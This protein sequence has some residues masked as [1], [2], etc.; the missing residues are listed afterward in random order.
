MKYLLSLLVIAFYTNYLSAQ[1]INDNIKERLDRFFTNYITDCSIGKCKLDYFRIDHNK[2]T[3]KIYPNVNFGYQ[4]FTKEKSAAIYDSIRKIL[5]GPVNYYSIQ[6]ISDKKPI[7]DLIPN[8]FSKKKDKS[9]ILNKK[10]E[11]KPWVTNKSKPFNIEKGLFNKH[12]VIWQ[13]HGKYYKNRSDKWEWQRPSLYCTNED[14]FSLSFVVPYVIPMLENAGANVFTPRER[15]W[16]RNEVIVDNDGGN[17]YYEK[18]SSKEKWKTTNMPGFANIKSQYSD[19]D[20]PFKNGTARYINT[21]KKSERAFAQWIPTI[22]QTGKYAVY[23]SYQTREESVDDAS[24]LVFHKGGVTRFSVNQKMGGGTWVYLGTFEFD[25]G[26]N[27]YGMVVLSNESKHKGVVCADAVRFGGGMGN[28]IRG[29][30]VSGLP[31]FLEG[32]RYSAQ[33]Y[34]MPDS[35]YTPSKG[36]NDYT[37]DINSRGR[38]ANYLS[39][40]S[41][42]NPNKTGLKVPID[43]CMG[44]HTDAGY[45]EKDSIIGTLG[46]YTT[47]YNNGILSSG[48]SRYSSRDLTDIMLT[49]IKKDISE[50]YNIPWTRRSMWNRNYSESRLPDVPSMILELMSHQNFSDIKLG[51]DPNFKFTVG[52]AVYK[53]ILKYISNIS[54]RDYVV[55]PLPIHNFAVEET[56]RNNTFKLSW[57][58][59][60]DKQEPSAVAQKYVV[61]TRIGDGGFDNGVIVKSH[62]YEFQAEPGIIYSFKVTAVNEGGESFPSEILSAYIAKESKAK[63]LIINAFKRVDGPKSFCKDSL[64]GF[65]LQSDIGIPY[66][67]TPEYCGEQHSFDI[68]KIGTG[69]SDELGASGHELEGK[70]IA[71][72]TFDYPHIHGKAIKKAGG[73]SFCSCSSESV[74]CGKIDISKYEMIDLIMGAEKEQY[75]PAMQNLITNYSKTGGNIFISGSYIGSSVN[76]PSGITFMRDILK[77]SFSGNM[78]LYTTGTIYGINREFRFPYTISE[79]SYAVQSPD[80]ILPIAPAYSTFVYT[81]GNF[82]AAVSYKGNY[83]TFVMGLP[84]ESIEGEVNRDIIMKAIINFFKSK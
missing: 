1:V 65:S 29:Q 53:S 74:E 16:Q 30:S 69:K 56:G 47:D 79:K 14:L 40:G 60:R 78:R 25:K 54:E 8:F 4:S 35:V 49:T 45:T 7:E 24:Y 27:D 11:G 73:F 44:I 52:R 67:C 15:D 36:T 51:H 17:I 50:T 22:P 48:M 6:V 81:P 9:R 62:E 83:R 2:R 18:S 82:G 70:I 26:S 10:Y 66:I 77:Y 13:S 42:Y 72:N 55:Q 3:I 37:D 61:Y 31:R 76:T 43:I 71:G 38:T 64:C 63:A 75:S 33:W 59:T 68:S 20:N 80:C 84:F 23:I 34:G 57:Q 12:I 46:I 39:A 21:E 28:I 58:D 32:A 41:I 19:F 5:P